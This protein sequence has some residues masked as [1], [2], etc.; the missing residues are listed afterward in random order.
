M[1]PGSSDITVAFWW[2]WGGGGSFRYPS[3]CGTALYVLS[4]ACYCPSEW[5]GNLE[6]CKTRDKVRE[7]EKAFQGKSVE[8]VEEQSLLSVRYGWEGMTEACE[9]GLGGE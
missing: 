4:R 9:G 3:R 6:E 2:W 7:A 1:S 5:K 8:T